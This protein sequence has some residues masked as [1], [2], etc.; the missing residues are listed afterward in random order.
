MESQEIIT[1]SARAERLGWRLPASAGAHLIDLLVTRTV[2]DLIA[3]LAENRDTAR[4]R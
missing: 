4:F 3:V 1:P 2:V